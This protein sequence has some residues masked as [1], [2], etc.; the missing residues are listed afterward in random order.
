MASDVDDKSFLQVVDIAKYKRALTD[1][2][3]N[4][5]RLTKGKDRRWL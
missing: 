4:L 1:L 5:G 3:D 2:T